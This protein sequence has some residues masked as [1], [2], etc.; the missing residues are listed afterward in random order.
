MQDI[1]WPDTLASMLINII[2]YMYAH[3]AAE[4]TLGFIQN[5]MHVGGRGGGGSNPNRCF[6][7][8]YSYIIFNYWTLAS[9][10]MDLLYY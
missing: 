6:V 5:T 10:F 9:D 8:T 7:H 1:A 2:M 4:T 3:I